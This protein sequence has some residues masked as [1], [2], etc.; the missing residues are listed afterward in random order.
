MMHEA[1]IDPSGAARFFEMLKESEGTG[2]LSEAM[3]W[4]STHPEHSDRIAAIEAQIELLGPVRER[5]LFIDWKAVQESLSK[6]VEVK[7]STS[8]SSER[9]DK[10]EDEQADN[11]KAGEPD[12][13]K[14]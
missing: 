6:A 3:S 11:E 14:E 10:N 9:P 7:D 8:E 4:V 1:G 12:S 13:H 5:D 2:E